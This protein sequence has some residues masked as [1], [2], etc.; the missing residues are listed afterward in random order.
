VP[1]ADSGSE[2]AQKVQGS[3]VWNSATLSA[4]VRALEARLSSLESGGGNGTPSGVP[5][6]V[7][8]WLPSPSGRTFVEWVPDALVAFVNNAGTHMLGWDSIHENVDR[9]CK[10]WLS[11]MVCEGAS[12]EDL[13]AF[14]LESDVLVK[15]ALDYVEFRKEQR[16]A[17][18]EAK[19]RE[20]G[21]EF[22]PEPVSEQELKEQ[23]AEREALAAIYA[24]RGYAT[25][26]ERVEAP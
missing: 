5:E 11:K 19:Q 25:D 9:M 20:A 16:M 2:Q 10:V 12:P 22:T 3:K 1:Q 8:R 24:D 17:A 18:I 26:V 15:R 21:V 6:P 14:E 13:F 23:E 4:K 7:Q